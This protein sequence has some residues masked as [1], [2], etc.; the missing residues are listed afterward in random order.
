MFIPKFGEEV[1]D[2]FDA[3]V[4]VNVS[5]HCNGAKCD[6]ASVWGKDQLVDFLLQRKRVLERE[7]LAGKNGLE[8]IIKPFS[9]GMDKACA[10]RANGASA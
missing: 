7:W 5:V 8:S 1:R 4:N 6:D 10:I 9:K 3:I 2:T